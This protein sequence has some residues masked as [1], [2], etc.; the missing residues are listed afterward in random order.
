MHRNRILTALATA[1]ALVLVG[2]DAAQAATGRLVDTGGQF[3]TGIVIAAAVVVVAGI[4]A[5]IISKRRGRG[6]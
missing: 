3:P 6:E 4:G 2:P 5:F 1:A